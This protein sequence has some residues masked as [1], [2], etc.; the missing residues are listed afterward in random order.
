M[1]HSLKESPT[2][3]IIKN[4]L[5]SAQEN[6]ELTTLMLVLAGASAYWAAD[7]F[8]TEEQVKKAI[9]EELQP[10]LTRLG[11]IEGVIESNSD[12]IYEFRLTSLQQERRQLIRDQNVI[13]RLIESGDA[14]ERDV[15]ELDEIQAALLENQEA[16]N[17]LD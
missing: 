3:D 15:A 9:S 11:S 12:S 14:T 16:I 2:V 8:A 6:F 1:L 10:V 13:E 5:K 7:T 17:N 4:F